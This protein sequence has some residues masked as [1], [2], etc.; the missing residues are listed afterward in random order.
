MNG[1]LRGLVLAILAFGD[2]EVQGHSAGNSL[3]FQRAEHLRRGINLSMWYAQ[4]KDFSPAHLD[5]M[6][7]TTDFA[8]I[9]SLGFDH[10]RL[11]ID[12]EW[13]IDEPQGGTLKAAADG[14]AGQDRRR[15]RERG[16]NVILDMHPE[17]SSS[18]A[19]AR[20]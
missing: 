5:A 2:D 3:A 13:L 9:K 7:N 20:R 12:P 16:L 18:R 6:I 15:A 11:S 10:V 1:W 8:M 14:A 17:E 19:G 4:T